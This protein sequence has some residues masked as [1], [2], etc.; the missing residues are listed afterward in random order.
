MSKSLRQ[1][2]GGSIY[3]KIDGSHA[4]R[5]SNGVTWCQQCGGFTSRWLR[6]LL[7]PC[8]GRPQTATR[9]NILRRLNLG[10]PPT[11]QDYLQR[12]AAESGNPEGARDHQGLVAWSAGNARAARHEQ[13][14]SD[15]APG[16]RLAIAPSGTYRRLA[17]HRNE[18][19][20]E[21]TV[22]PS[23][24]EAQAEPRRGP[25]NSVTTKPT[26]NCDY[27]GSAGLGGRLKV[28]A[29][30]GREPCGICSR[31]TAAVCRRCNARLCMTCARA[32]RRC[33]EGQSAVDT[34]F[35]DEARIEERTSAD[36]PEFVDIAV[37]A[38]VPSSSTSRCTEA[39]PK[40]RAAL[41][42]ALAGTDKTPGGPSRG[43][44]AT[45]GAL[46]AGDPRDEDAARRPGRGGCQEDRGLHRREGSDRDEGSHGGRREARLGR[47]QGVQSPSRERPTVTPP[48]MPLT[49]AAKFSCGA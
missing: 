18:G 34:T 5:A 16:P 2:C 25:M 21:T 22:A 17:A 13:R 23:A 7:E 29:H 43:T 36:T 44:A 45:G 11:A 28:L 8:R 20:G 38:S 19:V 6:S 12:V 46:L 42:M 26:M 24:A 41:L 14:H 27:E 10:L 4:L 49:S 31:P 47:A 9:R 48:P 3:D 32:K 1:H 35:T 37:V 30:P 15:G 39:E 40:S 33:Q